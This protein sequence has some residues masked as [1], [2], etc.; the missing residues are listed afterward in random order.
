MGGSSLAPEVLQGTF[1]AAPG[2]PELTVLDTTDPASILAL[3]RTL[4][5]PRT[6]FIVS[7][8]SGTTLETISLFRYLAAKVRART[9]GALGQLLPSTRPGAPAPGLGS[10]A[11]V[12]R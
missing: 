10:G 12:R 3:E 6:M 1:G 5:L 11:G 2:R 4:D 7:S 8:K 9:G